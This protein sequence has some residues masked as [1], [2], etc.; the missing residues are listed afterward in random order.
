MNSFVR[1]LFCS[2]FSI[3]LSH[4]YIFVVLNSTLFLTYFLCFVFCPGHRKPRDIWV[5]GHWI[6]VEIPNTL[7]K[8]TQYHLKTGHWSS[9][10]HF[11]PSKRNFTILWP[12]ICFIFGPLTFQHLIPVFRSPFFF[13]HCRERHS[14]KHC[15][16]H[17]HSNGRPKIMMIMMKTCSSFSFFFFSL[18][19]SLFIHSFLFVV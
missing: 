17:A 4:I 14:M 5:L 9:N 1:F 18:F 2:F 19:F 12:F 10:T 3:F 6:V 16:V 13:S 15:V 7:S 11:L 8:W